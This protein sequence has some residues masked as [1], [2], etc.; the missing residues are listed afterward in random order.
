M[1]TKTFIPVTISFENCFYFYY[2]IKNL[3]A[4]IV[5]IWMIYM[6]IPKFIQFL[7]GLKD[8]FKC[9]SNFTSQPVT[10]ITTTE[11]EQR[12]KWQHIA[13]TVTTLTPYGQYV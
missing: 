12:F 11:T 13:A 9:R 3:F 8:Y 1:V 7:I 2:K 10:N 6:V 4:C 5:G